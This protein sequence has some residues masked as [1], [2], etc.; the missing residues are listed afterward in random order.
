M[1]TC[2]LANV[3]YAIAG[4][5]MPINRAYQPP[6]NKHVS[7]IARNRY[8]TT[9]RADQLR[10]YD[11]LHAARHA[12]GA[13]VFTDL[14]DDDDGELDRQERRVR[15]R[16][17]PAPAKSDDE[18]ESVDDVIDRHAQA[19]NQTFIVCRVQCRRR[20]RGE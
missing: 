1:C 16:L 11:K 17:N 20:R 9:L 10:D 7:Q 2:M 3:T 4:D 19:F 8:Q 12:T 15:A 13:K 18:S 6:T 5:H 14:R